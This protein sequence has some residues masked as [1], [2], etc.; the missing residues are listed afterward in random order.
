VPCILGKELYIITK[1]L[2]FR[3]K[4]PYILTKEAYILTKEAWMIQEDE[5]GS[6]KEELGKGDVAQQTEAGIASDDV[7]SGVCCV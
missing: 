6:V 5:N 3:A 2:C 7:R 1:E 4:V